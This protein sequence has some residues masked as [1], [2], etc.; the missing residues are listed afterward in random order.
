MGFSGCV[1]FGGGKGSDQEF[2]LM[3]EVGVGVSKFVSVCV[4]VPVEGIP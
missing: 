2:Q 3:S 1:L 4:I